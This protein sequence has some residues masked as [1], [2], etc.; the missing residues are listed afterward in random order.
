VVSTADPTSIDSH[1]KTLWRNAKEGKNNFYPIFIPWHAVPG[2]NEE[3]FDRIRRD[4][5]LDWQ[6]K[7]NYPQSEDEALSPITGRTV[8]DAAILQKMQRD[9]I[10]EIEIRQGCVHI[11]RYPK[12]GTQYMAGVDMA[13]GR[14]GD[15]SVLWIE[16]KD[17]LGRELVAVIHTNLILPD[18]FS[19]M[20]FELLKEYFSPRVIGGADAFGTRFLEDLVVQGYDRGKIYCTDKKREK[21]GYIESVKTRDKDLIEMERAIRGNLQIHYIPAIKEFYAFQ[22]AEN[23]RMEA[24]QGSHDDLVM[25]ACKAN[26]GFTNYKYATQG[27]KVTYS[28]TWKG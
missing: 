21:L 7:A 25:A 2:R 17:G 18:T 23:G 3:W 5:D 19:Y 26:F 28:N 8:F 27:I 6:F 11:Y 4:Y 24:A 15:Y 1:F 20:S 22:Y 14:G 16:G 12:V 9:A 13:E 10:K